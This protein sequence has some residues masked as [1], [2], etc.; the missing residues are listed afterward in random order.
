MK[1]VYLSAKVQTRIDRLK[2]N[3]KAGHQLARKVTGIIE[4][5][6]SG[7]VNRHR[8]AVGSYT[9]YGEN[10]IKNCHKYDLGCGYRLITLQR[11][12]KVYIPFLGSHDDCQRWLSNNSR[13]KDAAVGKGALFRI[14][15]AGRLAGGQPDAGLVDSAKKGADEL[16]LELSDKELRR[17]FC[18]LV[19]GVEKGR[20]KKR[21]NS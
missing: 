3:G 11:G 15:P 16:R 21:G 19:E 5:L 1:C 7:T 20:V 10:R 4:S 8:D 2:K 9:K 14:L 12:S 13:M 18:G 17:V 6:T